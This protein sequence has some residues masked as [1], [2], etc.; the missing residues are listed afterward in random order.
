M[1]PDAD[2]R[3]CF[4]TVFML[5]DAPLKLPVHVEQQSEAMCAA[6]H[7]HGSHITGEEGRK[8]RRREAVGGQMRCLF[9]A[10]S[11]PAAIISWRW[12]TVSHC[13]FWQALALAPTA[14]QAACGRINSPQ[15]QG[16][17]HV[18]T[19]FLQKKKKKRIKH[20]RTGEANGKPKKKKHPQRNK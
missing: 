13:G 7:E 14:A 6:A 16:L 8:R 1:S 18:R 10:P 15:S 9:C 12:S 11:S 19:S 20:A 4:L 5:L 2:R 3:G 17:S